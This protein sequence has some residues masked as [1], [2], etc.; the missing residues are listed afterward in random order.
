MSN[1]HVKKIDVQ[2]V[3]VYHKGNAEQYTVGPTLK[4]P[5]T[6]VLVL[7]YISNVCKCFSPHA[8]NSTMGMYE[9]G[10]CLFMWADLR[11]MHKT[12]SQA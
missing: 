8:Y 2:Y 3:Y 12:L 9:Y 4:K 7:Q 5:H 6:T 1:C 11:D 10:S